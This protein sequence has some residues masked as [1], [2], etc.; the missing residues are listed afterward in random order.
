MLFHPCSTNKYLPGRPTWLGY[1]TLTLWT[2]YIL[3]CMMAEIYARPLYAE[4]YIFPPPGELEPEFPFVLPTMLYRW[5]VRGT[6]VEVLIMPV[7][8]S[9]VAAWKAIVR[10]LVAIWRMGSMGLGVS[11][12][13]IDDE[14]DFVGSVG[15]GAAR[16]VSSA[17][18]SVKGESMMN[19]EIL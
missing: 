18:A 6:G 9:V 17:I 19:D 2:Y 8:W 15:K 14:R 11:D 4:H 3:E 13:F 5:T 1:L 10:V 12:G 16:V 7:L